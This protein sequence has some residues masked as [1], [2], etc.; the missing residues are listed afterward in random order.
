MTVPANSGG[1]SV[2]RPGTITP[3]M[4]TFL[5]QRTSGAE[6][7]AATL[8]YDFNSGSGVQNLS[9][10]VL[11]ANVAGA[12]G[13]SI[14]FAVERTASGTFSGGLRIAVSG[15]A[16]TLTFS[17]LHTSWT[18]RQ[19]CDFINAADVPFTAVIGTNVGVDISP[20]N[21]Q[22]SSATNFTGGLDSTMTTHPF[23]AGEGL[24]FGA[25]GIIRNDEVL[26]YRTELIGTAT[27]DIGTHGRFN[28]AISGSIVLPA[29]TD[30]YQYCA[31]NLGTTEENVREGEYF[32][33]SLSDL[34]SREIARTS[35]T[36][37]I[38]G[39]SPNFLGFGDVAGLGQD[40]YLGRDGNNQLLV[41]ASGGDIDPIDLTLHGIL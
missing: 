16:T 29:N 1:I 34:L 11:T 36:Q 26:G 24:V 27:Y 22:R 39:L 4:T 38:V 13:N 6:A 15:D 19:I 32:Q 37:S 10:L 35:G 20:A 17:S 8:T 31:M 2:I 18:L 23:A 28:R 40:L 12:A 30:D 21:L 33:F 3:A 14:T 5:R 25:D 7:V 9:S 41:G